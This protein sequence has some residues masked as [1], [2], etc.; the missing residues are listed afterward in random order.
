MEN[1]NLDGWVF[2]YNSSANLWQCCKREHYFELFNGGENVFKSKD[3]KVLEEMIYKG[4]I[5]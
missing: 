2:S 4:K 1:N 3:F 5:C